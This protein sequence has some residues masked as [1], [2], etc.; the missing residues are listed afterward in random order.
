MPEFL[1][2]IILGACTIRL[3]SSM[4][5]SLLISCLYGY[6]FF[7]HQMT[8]LHVAAARGLVKIVE[9]LVEQEA[10]INIQDHKGVSIC[11]YTRWCRHKEGKCEMLTKCLSCQCIT[12]SCYTLVI[13]LCYIIIYRR[14]GKIRCWNNFAVGTNREN[15]KCENKTYA[16][17]INE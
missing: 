8:P 2:S 10:D 5:E 15:L 16:A 13:H 11:D 9:Y 6:S 17:M 7:S 4:P 3:H 1:S 14:S 12:G